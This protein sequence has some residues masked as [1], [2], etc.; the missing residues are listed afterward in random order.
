MNR[1]RNYYGLPKKQR[2][3]LLAKCFGRIAEGVATRQIKLQ[4]GACGACALAYVRDELASLVPLSSNSMYGPLDVSEVVMPVCIWAEN[5]GSTAT[6]IAE[7]GPAVGCDDADGM[8]DI[9]L[10]ASL[11]LEDEA[12]RL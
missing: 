3:L 12:A 1:N 2:L 9:L 4:P 5:D 10:I 6:N 7:Q 11:A 8:A